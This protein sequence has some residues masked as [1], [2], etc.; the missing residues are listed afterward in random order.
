ML[1]FTDPRWPSLKG[2]YR[3][4]IDIRPLL[5]RLE[6]AKDLQPAWDELWQE[7]YH[8]GDIGEASFAALPHLLRI[9]RQ[10]GAIDWNTYALAATIE[11]A[12][13]QGKNPDVPPW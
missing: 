7:L 4:P 12:R 3:I 5:Q 10:R 1:D 2:G 6:T 9:H 13:G 11:L 8:Q